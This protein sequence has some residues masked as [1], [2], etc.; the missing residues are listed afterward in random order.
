MLQSAIRS[1]LLAAL[2]AALSGCGTITDMVAPAEVD[3]PAELQEI[4]EQVSA[5]TVWDRDT[6]VGTAE[7]HLNLVPVLGNGHLFVADAEGSVSALSVDT[8]RVV[9][10]KELDVPASGGPG[11]GEG[12]VLL[13]TSDAEVI[14]LSAENG[15]EVWRAAVSS[16]VLAPPVAAFGR[17]IVRT[18]DGKVVGL[19]AASG[20]QKW[21]YVR[22]IPVLTLRGDSV[23]VVSHKAVL[24]GMAGGKLVALDIVTGDLLWE[25]TVSV[26]T[27]RSE[28][29]RLAD[30]DGDPLLADG[31]VYVTTYQG[32]IAALDEVSGSVLWRR[33][34][35]SYSGMAADR[36]NIYASDAD[37]L[38]WALD[39]DNGAARWK[40]DAFKNRQL[41]SVAVIGNVVA[42]GDFE[43]YVHF[44][45]AE[46]GR[47]VGRTRVGSAPITRGMLVVEDKLYVQGNDGELEALSLTNTR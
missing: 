7:Q 1:L 38:V 41:S 35:S 32:E 3:P 24:C 13:G 30:I 9:W 21:R 12:L 6:G 43:G 28:L 46:D 36:Y 10:S 47:Q 31:I 19:D 14:A 33:Q 18:I 44:L 16:E 20:E 40:Q 4:K 5:I 22:E 11:L 27:G 45:S 17:V 37:G 39:A 8:G 23:P 2:V 25:A 34:F 26:P 15:S 29:D 42:V